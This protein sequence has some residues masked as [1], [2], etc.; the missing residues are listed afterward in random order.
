[1]TKTIGDGEFTNTL[2]F[3]ANQ[4]ESTVSYSTNPADISQY[5]T[6]STSDGK[7]TEFKAAHNQIT[8]KA[9]VTEDANHE[10]TNNNLTYTLRIVENVTATGANAT[11]SPSNWPT[12]TNTL[13][14]TGDHG[15][16]QHNGQGL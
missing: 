5:A 3:S 15:T 4:G 13:N 12:N 14:I 8:V 16:T 11:G 7:F 2:T 1:M 6:F 10:C 9:T